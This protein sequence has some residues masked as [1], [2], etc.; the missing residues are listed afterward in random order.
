M[1]LHQKA[2]AGFHSGFLGASAAGSHRSAHQLIINLNVS[3]HKGKKTS[4]CKYVTIM[5]MKAK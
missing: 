4:M 5:C 3:S 1:C 2:Q